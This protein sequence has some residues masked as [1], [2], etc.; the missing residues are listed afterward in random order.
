[1]SDLQGI[2][3]KGGVPWADPKR[4]ERCAIWLEKLA[5][6]HALQPETLRLA[7]ADASFRRYL[8]LDTAAGGTRIVMDAPPDKENSAPFVHV[9]RLMAQAGLNVP[10]VLDWDEA[11]GFMLLPD[12]GTETVMQHA[13]A[14]LGIDANDP[15]FAR[16]H[17]PSS[18]AGERVAHMLRQAA[19]VAVQ[20]QLASKP[21]Q[22]PE[23]ND[24]QMQQE[25]M[26]FPDWY[27]ARHK[28]VVLTAA[29]QQSLQAM[30]GR[31]KAFNLALPQTYTHCD[32]MPRNLMMPFGDGVGASD[33][34]GVIDFQDAT[35]GPITH[36]IASLMRDAFT[37]WDDALVM[38]ITVRYWE[39][40]RKAGLITNGP[41]GAWSDDFGE[42]W[43]A[44]DYMALH[45]HLRIA[46]IFARLTH[47]DGKP[48]YVKDAP[49]FITYIREI[50]GRYAELKPL[51]KIID[52]V[53]GMD[54]ETAHLRR[55]GL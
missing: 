52:A 53:E 3:S 48:K 16:Q 51:L 44:V 37:S 9:A 47:R 40:A 7:T 26:L 13:Q 2:G 50:A 42:F 34:I 8:R 5:N 29:Q 30:F 14:L 32:F 46:G 20:W 4:A 33:Q 19:G 24:A 6:A 36:D 1:M 43:K 18:A 28:G 25:L 12:L 11:N 17:L 38:D 41:W 27:I 39:A 35:Y 15:P 22:L 23:H 49:R 55:F 45:R 21:G 31:I 10:K 54:A